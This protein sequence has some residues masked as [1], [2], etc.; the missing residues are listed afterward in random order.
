MRRL[1]ALLLAVSGLIAADLRAQAVVSGYVY[2]SLRTKGALVDANV[3]ITELNLFAIT[4]GSGHFVFEQKVP[5]G[6]W[7]VTFLHPVLD[8]LSIA[9]GAQSLTIR[10]SVALLLHLATPS[11]AT[12][13]HNVCPNA[14]PET[15]LVLGTVRDAA[16]GRPVPGA[17]IATEWR[18]EEHTSELQSH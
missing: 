1:R 18:S 10:D 8:S 5:A 4:D 11:P 15:G 3:V 6:T 2:D 16:S 17:T 9:A 7:T 12:L 14:E 13:V